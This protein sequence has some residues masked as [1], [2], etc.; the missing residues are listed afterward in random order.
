MSDLVSIKEVL[1]QQDG[2][3]KSLAEAV[4]KSSATS[5]PQGLADGSWPPLLQPSTPGGSGNVT[6]ASHFS[7][8]LNNKLL[9]CVSLAS[10]QILIDFGP[11]APNDPPRDKSIEAQQALRGMFNDWI[12]ISTPPAEDGATLLL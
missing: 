3:V 4:E 6:R 9:Q 12:D 8:P 10:K 2:F 5:N 7:S 11:P 1:V